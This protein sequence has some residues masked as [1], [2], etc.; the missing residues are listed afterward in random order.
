MSHPLNPLERSWLMLESAATPMHLGAL[1]IFRLPEDAGEG[2]VG[3]LAESLRAAGRPVA[4]WNL[5]LN[6]RRRLQPRWDE[7]PQPDLDYHLRHSAL[8]APGGE[9]ELGVL[10]SRLHSL[11]LDLSRPPWECHLIEGLHGGR[12]ALYVK[13]HHALAD[14]TSFLRMLTAWLSADP[15]RRGT[16]APW[17]LALGPSERGQAGAR[18]QT[19]LRSFVRRGEAGRS[20]QELGGAMWRLLRK[21][22]APGSALSAPYRAPRSALNVH[23]DAQRRFATQQYARA[24]LQ[25][26]ADA[27]ATTL[28]D[29]VLYLCGTALRRFFKE[30]N[31]LPERS[32]VAAVPGL[33]KG[34]PD[35]ET[36]YGSI[37]F[38]SLGTQL[39]DPRKRLAEIRRSAQASR[40][41][42][43]AVPETLIPLYTLATAAPF[44]LGQLSGMNRLAPAMFN[45]IIADQPGPA[46]P[47]YSNGARLEALYPMFPLTQGG[48][49]SITCLHYADTLNLGFCGARATLPSLQRMAV[50]T[51]QALAEL[52]ESLAAGDAHE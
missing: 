25:R 38:V 14:V 5:K 21:S 12:Y 20:A 45:L 51:G 34:D 4:P 50:Y 17:T 23:I 22:S 33:R 40:E 37:G 35:A 28:D 18:L 27:H 6:R 11:A 49:L 1:L 52:E 9:R 47:L 31:A 42:L 41:H 43:D 48:A 24:R 36:P 16:S 39:A 3:R 29:L 30:Y 15:R 19:S 10:V 32:F 46:Q 26:V 44:L 8:P 13:L 2:A 7:D